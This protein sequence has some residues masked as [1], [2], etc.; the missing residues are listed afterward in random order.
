MDEAEQLVP[1]IGTE[2]DANINPS[3]H[4]PSASRMPDFDEKDDHPSSSSAFAAGQYDEP[5]LPAY[6]YSPP[7]SRKFD[8]FL[9]SLVQDTPEEE[10]ATD[11]GA[12]AF[13][14][15]SSS[16]PASDSAIAAAAHEAEYHLPPLVIGYATS[17]GE[18]YPAGASHAQLDPSYRQQQQQQRQ[19]RSAS[20]SIPATSLLSDSI[21]SRATASLVTRFRNEFVMFQADFEAEYHS[22]RTLID[23]ASGSAPSSSASTRA[24]NLRGL[25]GNYFAAQC[26]FIIFYL[27]LLLFSFSSSTFRPDCHTRCRVKLE[28]T[29]SSVRTEDISCENA[30][31]RLWS[32]RP[33]S[34]TFS[35]SCGDGRVVSHSFSW[36]IAEFNQAA[37]AALATRLQLLSES[38]IGEATL[39]KFNMLSSRVAV[40]LFVHEILQRLHEMVTTEVLISMCSTVFFFASPTFRVC[41]LH[42][43]NSKSCSTRHLF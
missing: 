5:G 3:S 21:A 19:N 26:V 12:G 24:D 30:L 14:F 38:K 40:E 39:C 15:R 2:R 9:S 1:R 43:R 23:G 33:I 11:A 18:A 20:S 31:D 42:G 17:S 35:A 8:S 28:E 7:A 13:V 41:V 16:V 22:V 25:I 36:E 6:T 34:Q 27:V 10:E 29:I 37:A 32:K 4:N